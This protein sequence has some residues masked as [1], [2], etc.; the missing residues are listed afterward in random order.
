MFGHNLSFHHIRAFSICGK[1]VSS[2]SR[3]VWI[4]VSSREQ[5]CKQTSV[6]TSSLKKSVKQIY[7][8]RAYY[9]NDLIKPDFHQ[10]NPS[11]VV[12]QKMGD[13]IS[14]SAN[15]FPKRGPSFLKRRSSPYLFRESKSAF[16]K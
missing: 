2:L 10:E 12:H 15:Q 4:R 7:I 8:L 9:L 16:G 1:M 11:M 13:P 3:M 14:E 5:K 6:K